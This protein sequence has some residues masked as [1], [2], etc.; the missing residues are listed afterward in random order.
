MDKPACYADELIALNKES[1]G[2]LLGWLEA[3]ENPSYG[4]LLAKHILQAAKA[5]GTCSP[6][7]GELAED[8]EGPEPAGPNRGTEKTH[9]R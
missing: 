3:M 8:R 6:S 2:K 1:E 5:R 9:G 4:D 7:P